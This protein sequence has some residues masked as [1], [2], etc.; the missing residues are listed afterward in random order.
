MAYTLVP[1]LDDD[2]AWLERLWRAVY[3]ELFVATFGGWD[4]VRHTRQFSECWQRG[5]IAIIEVAGER[6]GMIQRF[7]QPQNI[8]VGEMQV[9]P[10]YQNLGIGSSVLRD[11][12]AR[13]QPQQKKVT[14]SVALKNERAYRLYQRLGFHEV[15]RSET[16][17]FMAYD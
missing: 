12:I 15:G 4:E 7:E 3:Q 9:L 11:T 10:S 5:H 6:V 13:A 14:L 17:T 1:A 8:E 2:K 16:H